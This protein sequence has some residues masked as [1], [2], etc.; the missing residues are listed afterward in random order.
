MFPDDCLNL[1]AAS[2]DASN[3]PSLEDGESF[4]QSP[5]SPTFSSAMSVCS[6]PMSLA[7]SPEIPLLDS[8][9]TPSAL[10]YNGEYNDECTAEY[11]EETMSELAD[12]DEV[13]ESLLGELEPSIDG[14][15]RCWDVHAEDHA[16]EFVADRK[17]MLR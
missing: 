3:A 2:S 17:C 4:V 14:K 1:D 11:N 5:T 10:E 12:S 15:Y 6:G 8:T 16:C 7:L 9:A 13:L